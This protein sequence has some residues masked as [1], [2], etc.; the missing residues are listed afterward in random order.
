[1]M[2]VVVGPSARRFFC[3]TICFLSDQDHMQDA[4]RRKKQMEHKVKNEKRSIPLRHVEEK[5]MQGFM[6]K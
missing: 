3:P 2:N 1:M 5:M 6:G 4:A